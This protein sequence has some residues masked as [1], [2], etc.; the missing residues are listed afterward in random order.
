MDRKEPYTL[1][2]QHRAFTGPADNHVTVV[3]FLEP[4]SDLRPV[5]SVL[6]LCPFSCWSQF[7]FETAL[8]GYEGQTGMKLIDHP[9]AMQFESCRSVESITAVLRE[10]LLNFEET[11]MKSLKGTVSPCPSSAFY[12]YD[13]WRGYR[14]VPDAVL[15]FKAIKY[16]SASYDAPIELLE[17]IERLV[18]RLDTRLY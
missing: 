4:E 9:L 12:Q 16:V 13:S 2:C 8:L 14:S 18:N 17:S 6:V 11:V 10:P 3:G 1:E 5:M 15:Q 7:F